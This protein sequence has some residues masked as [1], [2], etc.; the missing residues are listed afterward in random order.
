MSAFDPNATSSDQICCDAQRSPRRYAPR[1]G[2]VH[3]ATEF[4]G[5]VGGAKGAK[6]KAKRS[7]NK[8]TKRGKK[9]A[10]ENRVKGAFVDCSIE[11]VIGIAHIAGVLHL[12]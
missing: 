5:L 6:K 1:K 8:A 3:A 9:W 2:A 10:D 7:D 12:N 11:T 4:I